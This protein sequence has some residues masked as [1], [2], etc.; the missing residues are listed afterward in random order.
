MLPRKLKHLN[1]FNEGESF[2]GQIQEVVLPNLDR[3]MEEYRGGGMNA[4]IKTDHGLE[5]ISFEWTCGGF[6]D[7]VL[8]QFGVLKHDGVKLRFH[9]AYQR[10]DKAA[11][12]AV[13]ITITGRH[14]KIDMGTAKTGDE[15]PFKITTEI[16]YIKVTMNDERLVEIDIMN[17][18]EFYGDEDRMEPFR[19]ALGI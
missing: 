9:G 14:S 11:V 1:L 12:D 7:Q 13:E 5:A 6:M 18:I 4:P 19:T 16:S 2:L 8:K 15:S 3:K 10:D 17:A